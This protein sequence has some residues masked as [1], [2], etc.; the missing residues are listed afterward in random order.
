MA[1]PDIFDQLSS[2]KWRDIEFP[3]TRMRMTVAHDLVEHK[4]YGVD[5]ARVESVGL[6]PLRFSFSS[7]LLNGIS[8]GKNERWAALYP[9]QMRILLAA[10]QKKERG[11]LQH[12]EFGLL[13]CK[14]ERFDM[15]WDA[16]RRGGVDAELTFVQTLT[17][18]EIE[19]LDETPVKVVDIGELDDESLKKDL[20]VLLKARNLPLPP[21]LQKSTLSLT[22]FADKVKAIADAP[23]LLQYRAAGRIN[24]IL[25]HAKR[26]QQSVEKARSAVT[27]PV[28][29]SVER[30]RASAYGLQ[31]QILAVTNKSI[32]FFKVPAATTL[33]GVAR[34]LPGA[35]VGD[36]IKLNPGLM[37]G[38][39]IDAGTTV[40]YYAA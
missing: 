30:S 36:L 15:D 37:R 23:T 1:G 40:R 17:D 20:K 34:Q 33:A 16:A 22:E 3:V 10:F 11:M 4:Y 19:V 31:E 9:N 13:V 5:G 27:W 28:T 7:P 24:S 12:P 8:P 18:A 21:Y 6:A 35:K 38:P 2:A 32:A 26:V 25:Y 39:E 29:Q 14:A